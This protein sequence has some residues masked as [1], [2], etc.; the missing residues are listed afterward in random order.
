MRSPVFWRRSSTAAGIYLSALLGFLG[1]VVAV[2]ELGIH[3]FGLLALVL[4]ATG[5][6][7]LF[8]DLTVQ[9]ALV[10]YGFRYA[11]REDWGRFRRLFRVGLELKLAGGALGAGAVAL[12]APFSETIWTGDLLTPLLFAALLPLVQAPEGV[13]AAALI[14]RG[15][16]DV[17]AGFLVV[18]MGLRLAALAVG[19]LFGVVETVIALVV[20]QALSTA[21]I[22]AAA[23]RAL[24]RFPRPA[25]RPLADDR[26]SFRTFVVRSSLG[27]LLSPVRGPLGALLLGVVAGPQQVAYLRVAQ[28]PESAF[29]ALSAPARLILLAEQTDDV[30]RGRDERV[31]RTLRGYILGASALTAVLLPPLALLMPTLLETVF[32]ESAVPAT[33]AA[34]IFLLVAAI[35]LVWGWAKSFAVSIGRPELRLFA[36]GTEVLVLVPALLAL[37]ATYGATGAASAFLIGS[38]AFAGVATVLALRLRREGPI[39]AGPD[40]R[41]AADFVVDRKSVV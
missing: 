24:G 28:T 22:G 35:Q 30:E 40:A 16:Y 34:R 31:Y 6:F 7:Q 18:A 27:S 29:T 14:V 11:V 39:E 26:A 36:Q 33:D 17:R 12:L 9:D 1:T 21:T 20:A 10:K 37:G 41:A 25:P 2:R 8:A 23:V 13:A 15:R 5:F 32:G 38:A 4:A 19:G 3:D